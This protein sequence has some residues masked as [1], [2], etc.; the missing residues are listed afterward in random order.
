[1]VLDDR[2]LPMGRSE[3][4]RIAPGLL[5]EAVYDDAFDGPG[6]PAE[7]VLARGGRRVAL[8]FLE[9]YRFAQVY[10]PRGG[11]FISFEPMTAPI[12]P[13]A[14]SRTLLAAR[15]SPYRARFAIS[16]G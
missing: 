12:N 1:M 3:R 2:M 7:F 5:G 9:G 10:A 15:G 11:D 13:F 6:E 14:D 4:A 16:M 8:R